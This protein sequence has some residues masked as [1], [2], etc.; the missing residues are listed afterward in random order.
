MSGI[1]QSIQT[2]ITD[3]MI[4]WLDVFNRRSAQGAM[5]KEKM[6][7]GVYNDD[8]IQLVD[9][10]LQIQTRR[11]TE[12]DLVAFFDEHKSLYDPLLG[13][14]YMRKAILKVSKNHHDAPFTPTA[15]GEY[16]KEGVWL[17]SSLIHDPSQIVAW[18]Y[19]I[20]WLL[21]SAYYEEEE[22]LVTSL[23]T[24]P[25]VEFLNHLPYSID[26]SLSCVLRKDGASPLP[27]NINDIFSFLLHY[28]R[29][30]LR[31]YM[32]STT[33]NKQLLNDGG[34]SRQAS[35]VDNDNVLL[36]P[37]RPT[38]I[39]ALYN[40]F[41][42]CGD[43]PEVSECSTTH[44][45][46]RELYA[47]VQGILRL[48]L[49]SAIVETDWVFFFF[50]A[51]FQILQHRA[52]KKEFTPEDIDRIVALLGSAEKMATLQCNVEGKCFTRLCI[53]QFICEMFVTGETAEE[54]LKCV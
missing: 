20:Q 16:R 11:V 52:E 33:K 15:R 9:F 12:A 27:F 6:M 21:L 45:Q 42:C 40:A 53:A 34:D 30:Y 22:A 19:F 32:L 37:F 39:V 26:P 43:Q 48:T 14:I 50:S 10:F 13:Y 7:I 18:R 4:D 31:K 36:F 8:D 24:T 35:R 44:P 3:M 41:S 29:F 38:L 5:S 46:T 17:A 1:S 49:S 23:N 28:H 25:A 54:R 2:R 47:R 51:F